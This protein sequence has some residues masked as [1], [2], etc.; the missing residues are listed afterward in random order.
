MFG[1]GA[2]R[3]RVLSDAVIE[4]RQTIDSAVA[5][6]KA[7]KNDIKVDDGVKDTVMGI[8]T[9][10]DMLTSQ[11]AYVNENL[12]NLARRPIVGMLG[13]G[14]EQELQR[15]VQVTDQLSRSIRE[16]MKLVK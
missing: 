9:S 4:L 2:Q 10:I 6:I 8:K 11:L 5:A 16:A 7:L 13:G 15:L 1:S 12:A 14:A 3:I